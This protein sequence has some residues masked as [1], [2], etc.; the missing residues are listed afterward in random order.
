MAGFEELEQTPAGCAAKECKQ[1]T[2]RVGEG[3]HVGAARLGRA[4][5]Q[6]QLHRRFK[7]QGALDPSWMNVEAA[8]VVAMACEMRCTWC[9]RNERAQQVCTVTR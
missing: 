4:A 6:D 2:P 7:L 8:S 9:C 1:S 5:L 3:L